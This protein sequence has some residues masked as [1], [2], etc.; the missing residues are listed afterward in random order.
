M[1]APT[2]CQVHVDQKTHLSAGQTNIPPLRKAGSESERLSDV[3]F[4][5]AGKIG[6]QIG[7]RAARGDRFYDHSRCNAPSSDARLA[8]H[9]FRIDSDAPEFVHTVI[10]PFPDLS[11]AADSGS[12]NSSVIRD[13]RP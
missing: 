4:L 8:A 2:R 5:D 11:A 6:Q 1:A 10:V 12:G 3:L 7:N 9:H 13:P